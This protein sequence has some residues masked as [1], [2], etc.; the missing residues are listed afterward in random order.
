MLKLWMNVLTPSGRPLAASGE[1]TF[2]IA[3]SVKAQKKNILY[4]FRLSH[5]LS[6]REFE[7]S[8]SLFMERSI[9]TGASLWNT[10]VTMTTF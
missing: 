9:S 8:C 1:G 5:R 2:Q 3:A 7:L 10:T 4:I 6:S